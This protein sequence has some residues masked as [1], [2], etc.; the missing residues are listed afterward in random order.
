MQKIPF[1]GLVGIAGFFLIGEL[2]AQRPG[3]LPGGPGQRPSGRQA[4]QHTETESQPLR[5]VPANRNPPVASE[6]SIKADQRGVRIESNSIPDHKVGRFPK[7][8]AGVT[9][10]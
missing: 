1:I 2:S 6:V 3:P 4:R 7:G 10:R 9:Q 5:L 8:V